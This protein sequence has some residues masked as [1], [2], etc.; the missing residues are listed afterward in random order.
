MK[1]IQQTIL[2]LALMAGLSPAFAQAPPPVPALPDTERRTSYSI[3]G[4]TCAC[5]VNFALYGDSTD[6]G[7]WLEVF[8]NGVLIS[9][10]AYTITSPTGPLASIPRPVTDAVL[11]FTAAQTGT[12]QIVGARRPR[13]VSQFTEGRG[14]AA[15]DLN[16]VLTDIIAQNRETW[17][18]INDVSGRVPLALP[19]ETLNLLPVLANRLNQ[20][21]CFDSGGNLTTCVSVPASTFAAGPGITFTGTNPT[22]ISATTNSITYTIPVTGGVARTLTSKLAESIS[23]TDFG[24]VCNGSTDDTAA[25]TAAFVAAAGSKVTLPPGGVACKVIGSGSNIFA[26]TGPIIFDCQGS[27]LILD[28]TVPNTRSLFSFKP[29]GAGNRL[30][31][32]RITRCLFNMNSAG[33]NV[34]T[35]DTTATNTTEIGEF[36]IDHVRDTASA[37]ASSYSIN[38]INVI[39]N[40]NGGL[41]NVNFHD[42][43]LTNGIFLANVGDSIRIK[44]NILTG[45]RF[46]VNV[47]LIS[48]A[49][50]LFIEGNNITAADPILVDSA[51]GNVV[52]INN[53]I[54]EPI[55]NTDPSG[56]MVDLRGNIAQIGHVTFTGNSVNA[57]AGSGNPNPLRIAGVSSAYVETNSFTSSSAGVA[58]VV[59]TASAAATIIGASNAYIGCTTT[60]SNSGTL[61]YVQVGVSP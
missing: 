15:R 26:L 51:I 33:N 61:K 52:I 23:V 38:A 29:P 3:S 40:T 8:V 58:C 20:G 60:V 41:F 5:A 2:A 55:T 16:Q 43:V 44:D 53:E 34:I 35:I 24:A 4:T 30:P 21:A 7:N 28:A 45:A 1:I 59:N 17:D 13:R 12:V 9:P 57:L 36:E 37:G 25:I 18:K 27:G 11:T 50:G 47:E 22:T 56:A 32:T 54:E 46:G 49:A 14:V 31:S 19:G 39:G 10:S 6:Y 48:G 42:N